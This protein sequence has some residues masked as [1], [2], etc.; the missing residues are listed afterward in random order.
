[1]PAP[2]FVVIGNIAKDLAP[3][4]FT[5]GGTCTFAAA[6]AH[7]LGLRTGVVTRA[8]DDV[9]VA[10]IMPFADV[11]QLPSEATTTFENVY[12][13]GH[14]KQRILARA[15]AIVTGDV[16]REWRAAPII[17]LGPLFGEID[18]SLAADLAGDSLVGVSAQGWLR[19]TDDEQHV[20]RTP[21][22][23]EPFWH[24]ADLVFVSD[25][26]LADNVDQLDGWQADAR[27]I[28]MTESSRGLRIWADG[29][30]R[31][32][33]AYPQDEI[34]PTGAGDTFATAFLIRLHETGDPAEAARFGA[35]AA[36]I[37]IG[38][39]GTAATPDRAQIE[40]R[41]RAYPEVAL[42]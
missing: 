26:D 16:P 32:M 35:A 38:G 3:G 31:R 36:S 4:G 29:A 30:W 33:D 21:W 27:L 1:M 9:A 42:R 17:L 24:G 37:S 25:E 22:E 39:I 12:D 13:G 28:A 34:D 14:R 40:E 18:A 6:Q 15:G 2:D 19:G 8:G 7:R 10:T 5:P 23:G 11:V 20:V 41:M